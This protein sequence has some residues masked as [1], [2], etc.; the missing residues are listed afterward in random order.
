M[1]GREKAG[2]GKVL[3]VHHRSQDKPFPSSRQEMWLFVTFVAP[4]PRSGLAQ[5]KH[6]LAFYGCRMNKWKI[7]AILCLRNTHGSGG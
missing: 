2:Q 7:S 1:S 6:Q 5:S 3:A 4:L